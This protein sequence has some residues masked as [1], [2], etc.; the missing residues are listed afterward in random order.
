M[1]QYYLW[2]DSEIQL[3]H[4]H[5]S[6]LLLKHANTADDSTPVLTFQTVIQMLQDDVLGAIK[7]Q[8]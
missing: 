1:M 3:I 6:G 8:R 5:N 7:F 2:C 4:S